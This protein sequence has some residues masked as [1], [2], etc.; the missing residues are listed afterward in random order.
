MSARM[1]EGRYEL[2]D[3][4]GRGGQ[5][6]V[7][8]ALDRALDRTVALKL[9]R[10]EGSARRAAIEA[11]FFDEAR[12]TARLEHPGI[13]PVHDAGRLPDGRIYLAMREVT[14]RTLHAVLA[15]VDAAVDAADR[16]TPDGWTRRRL[17][18]ALHRAS[19]AV[20]YAHAQ[21]I[22]HLDITPANIVLGSFGEV[23]VLDWG[24]GGRSGGGT[25]GFASPEQ[26]AGDP[27]APTM[28]VYA[29]GVVLRA[30]AEPSAERDPGFEDLLVLA[31]EACAED[32]ADRF[33]DA[34]ALAREL[35]D[36]LDGARRREAALALVGEGDALLAASRERRAAAAALRDEVARLRAGVSRWAPAADKAAL[37][38]AEDAAAAARQAADEAEDRALEAWRA[39]LR[40]DPAEPGAHARLA[41]WHR[42][43]HAAAEVAG[44]PAAPRLLRALRAHDRGAHAGYLAARG[45]LVLRL[46][47][48]GVA[49]LLRY[50]ERGRRLVAE[51]VEAFGET[52]TIGR[53]LPI[54]SYVVEVS[55]ARYPVQ[56]G[57]EAVW[58]GVIRPVAPR[59]GEI[60]VPE[61]PAWLGSADPGVR[62]SFSRRRALVDAFFIQEFPVT[63]A[64]F[65]VFL[66]DLL[67]EERGEQAL[68]VAPRHP[69]SGA[70]EGALVYGRGDDGRFALVPDAEGDVWAADWPAVLVRYD[71]AVAYAA[72]FAARTGL[73]WRLPEEWEWEKAARG[74]DGRALP[75]GEHLDPSF[76]NMRFT[77]PDRPLLAAVTDFP[78]DVSP[79]GVR[80]MAGNT[81]DWTATP[82]LAA[83][84]SLD[85]AGRPYAP[86]SQAGHRTCKG[87]AWSHVD[88]DCRTDAR[89]HV[90]E[91]HTRNDIG[92]RLA[93][94]VVAADLDPPSNWS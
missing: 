91:G 72:W 69:G 23:F 13:V 45:T 43:A 40:H 11:D 8:R 41:D 31:L 22:C 17:V 2:R 53:S 39:A 24:L 65:L 44:D 61:G 15:A 87:G 74:V 51:L 57:R 4:I 20:G 36:W 49:R 71:A 27:P 34:G 94:C 47:P 19:E 35:A 3:L 55:G 63:N 64:D 28:D 82:F 18:D 86:P 38:A 32:P 5:G 46:E 60:W 6:E 70:A 54:G 7:F 26:L 16:A 80:G 48:P 33:P 10:L 81:A 62:G 42:D 52:A 79:Y 56:I 73:P 37:W 12:R 1:N 58:E 92:L 88:R 21:G 84:P 25:P 67:D 9:P 59:R 66:N 75:W 14:G 89:W 77:R 85:A 78:D 76:A 30:V 83:G 68:A 93:R 29:L 50:A 90:P